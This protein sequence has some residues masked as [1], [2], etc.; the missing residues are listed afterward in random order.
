M[1]TLSQEP[2][3]YEIRTDSDCSCRIT[4]GE[5]EG[6]T[7]SG[8]PEV[9][10]VLKI[11]TIGS[12]RNGINE[13]IQ[14][15]LDAASLTATFNDVG[16]RTSFLIKPVTHEQIASILVALSRDIEKPK[17]GEYFY[18]VMPPKKAMEI[19]EAECEGKKASELKL[20]A[21]HA[22]EHGYL[23][24]EIAYPHAPVSFM[25]EDSQAAEPKP[26]LQTRLELKEESNIPVQ[27][28]LQQ[29]EIKFTHY[30]KTARPSPYS[31]QVIDDKPAIIA[32]APADQVASAL[33][34]AGL[35]PPLLASEIIDK[36]QEI[37]PS[38]SAQSPK[39]R[40]FMQRIALK[41]LTEKRRGPDNRMP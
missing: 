19:I 24:V 16:N 15:Q 38:Q 17:R 13:R 1:T 9:E 36:A 27:R 4:V 32:E 22:N 6:D 8:E 40:A 34:V 23:D 35:L 2:R 18:A 14:A 7:I 20:L 41:A 11:E 31:A 37:H 33:R 21:I 29:A 39:T 3:T 5:Y 25:C 10:K 26:V 28:A 30:A 12:R